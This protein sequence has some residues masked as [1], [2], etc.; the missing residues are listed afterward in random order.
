MDKK[1]VRIK[2]E[3]GNLD[4]WEKG[5][6]IG[7]IAGFLYRI[8]GLVTHGDIYSIFDWDLFDLFFSFQYYF[9]MLLSFSW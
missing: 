8:S 2:K 6:I 1:I 9:L 4:Y 7:G 3:G 5:G